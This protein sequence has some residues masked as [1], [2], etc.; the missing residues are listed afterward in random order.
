MARAP[1]NKSGRPFQVFTPFH[2]AWIDHGVHDPASAVRASAPT[3]SPPR[4]GST[5][6]RP[7]TSWSPWPAR[8]R[9]GE[10]WRAWLATG[11]RGG[12][13]YPKLH[14][15]PGADATS[16]LSIALRWGHLHPRTVLNDLA[17]QRSDGASRPGPPDR[18]AGLLRRC[19]FHRPD[20]T[21]EPI[22]PEFAEMPSDEPDRTERP[23]NSS[24]AWQ[25]G[26]T[27]YPLVDAGMRQLLAEGW[28][29]N[30]VRMVVASFLI[31]DL[32]I[33]WWH[34]RRLV[35]GAPARR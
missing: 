25:Q 27:G 17:E 18:L 15:V 19:L 20:A 6:R 9:R 13:A 22:R 3:G 7:T 29:H 4:I 26:R 21:S 23:P 30:R 14:D 1:V 11:L 34:G 35:H 33:G 16:H 24:K 31:K 32:H 2:R 8:R 5:C 12:A 28:M 10:Q